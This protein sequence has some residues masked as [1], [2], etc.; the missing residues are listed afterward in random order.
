VEEYLG[1]SGLGEEFDSALGTPVMRPASP[2]QELGRSGIFPIL[3]YIN[4]LC[5]HILRIGAVAA[6][7]RILALVNFCALESQFQTFGQFIRLW[8]KTPISMSK[9]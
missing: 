6:S 3:F 8:G 1:V 2:R 7:D 9:Y 5:H 4:G